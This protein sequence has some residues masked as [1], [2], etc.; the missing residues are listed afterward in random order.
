MLSGIRGN[1]S[2]KWR[3]E[4][5]NNTVKWP[6]R[7]TRLPKNVRY[8]GHT[9]R[10]LSS[11][12]RLFLFLASFW[13]FCAALSVLCICGIVSLSPFYQS[14]LIIMATLASF[15]GVVGL[16]NGSRYQI[17]KKNCWRYDAF[18]WCEYLICGRR[19]LFTGCTDHYWSYHWQWRE[20]CA[21]SIS[22]FISKFDCATGCYR[23][24]HSKL[25]F[26]DVLS[27]YNLFRTYNLFLTAL[28]PF[29]QSS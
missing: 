20:I 7:M 5:I 4:K 11:F 1:N 22:F 6:S 15:Q 9:A 21:F 16:Q 2:P 27:F 25:H 14:L 29:W 24:L 19:H 10:M 18:I 28:T 3:F 26:P 17:D 13:R 12:P 8:R 23:A